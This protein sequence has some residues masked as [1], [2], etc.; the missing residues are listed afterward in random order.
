MDVNRAQVDVGIAPPGKIE[1]LFAVEHPARTLQQDAQQAELGG[2]DM[3]G[4]SVS[5]DTV[6]GHIESETA[7]G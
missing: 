7:V 3:N 1:Q 5:G 4:L 2:P 6:C